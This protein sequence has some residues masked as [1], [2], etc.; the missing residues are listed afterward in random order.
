MVMSIFL[1]P[2]HSVWALSTDVNIVRALLTQLAIASHYHVSQSQVSN[3]HR[4]WLSNR[5]ATT[6]LAIFQNKGVDKLQLIQQMESMVE[7]WWYDKEDRETDSK[8]DTQTYQWWSYWVQRLGPT[9]HHSIAVLKGLFHSCPNW[10]RKSLCEL[11]KHLDT[12]SHSVRRKSRAREKSNNGSNENNG[13]PWI[14][15]NFKAHFLWNIWS[16]RLSKTYC[17]YS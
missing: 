16:P 12:Q 11:C 5:Y 4:W 10:A 15:Y 6:Q 9:W 14:T 1:S 2:S 13:N 7:H 17:M 3:L 8:T